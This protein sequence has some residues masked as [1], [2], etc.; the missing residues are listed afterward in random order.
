MS[1]SAEDPVFASLVQQA[2]EGSDQ[3]ARELVQTYSRCIL[4]HGAA[5]AEPTGPRQV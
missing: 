5:H 2:A 3:A 1:M 4:R